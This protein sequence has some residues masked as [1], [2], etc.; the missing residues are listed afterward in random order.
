MLRGGFLF[1]LILSS[2]VTI[3]LQLLDRQGYWEVR[4]IIYFLV[5]AFIGMLISVLVWDRNEKKFMP[6]NPPL[7][8]RSRRY[9]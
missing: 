7:P 8:R 1:G 9:Q 2:V 6:E 4:L 3:L 5:F